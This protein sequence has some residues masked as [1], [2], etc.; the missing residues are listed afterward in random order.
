MAYQFSLYN[1]AESGI[2]NNWHHS[3]S[4]WGYKI[5]ITM[6]IRLKGVRCPS[7]CALGEILPYGWAVYNR[8]HDCVNIPFT[9]LLFCPRPPARSPLSYDTV[10]N[11]RRTTLNTR[12]RPF[13]TSTVLGRPV[14]KSDVPA[15]FEASFSPQSQYF[16]APRC[17]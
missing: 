9:T 15:Q 16:L 3:V 6:A 1:T 14:R 4:D 13:E 11:E 17:I 12:A 10:T 2:N 5:I 8:A 7:L